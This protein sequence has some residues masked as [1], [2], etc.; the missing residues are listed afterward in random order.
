MLLGIIGLAIIRDMLLEH[1]NL[2]HTF[3]GK[4][5][6]AESSSLRFLHSATNAKNALKSLMVK[7]HT[8]DNREVL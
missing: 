1:S 5:N 7:K 8:V 6:F 2:I 3:F 4:G